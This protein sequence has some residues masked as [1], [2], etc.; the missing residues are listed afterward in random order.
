MNA[1]R[2][3]RHSQITTTAFGG[4][5]GFTERARDKSAP[6]IGLALKVGASTSSFM[7]NVHLYIAGRIQAYRRSVDLP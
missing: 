2:G 1:S 5:G 4:W 3:R 7:A 6:D